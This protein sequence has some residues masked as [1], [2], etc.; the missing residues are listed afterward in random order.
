MNSE[1]RGDLVHEHMALVRKIA[2]H[3]MVKLPTSVQI[4]DLIQA[5]SMGLLEATRHYDGTRGASFETFAGI[6]IRGAMLDEV[7]RQNWAP[8]SSQQNMRKI[9]EAVRTVEGRL[10][11]RAV[12][13]EIAEEMGLDLDSYHQ[14]LHRSTETQLLN[15]EDIL[16][17]DVADHDPGSAAASDPA[18]EYEHQS[19]G[20]AIRNAIEALPEMDKT[21]L[22][23]YYVEELN[24]REIGE[25]FSL[26]ETR[27]SQIRSRAVARLQARL[28]AWRR[29]DRPTDSR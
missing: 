24:L 17:T 10:G 25:V 16:G 23:L 28:A 15:V 22:S 12:A 3:L 18:S 6:R 4:D 29:E 26:T 19:L 1:E 2:G 20:T 27:I 7:R 11:R 21:V 5:G 9:S 13:A 14:L 8:R